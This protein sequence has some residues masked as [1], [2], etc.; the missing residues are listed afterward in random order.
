MNVIN[1][2][3]VLESNRVFIN[4]FETK[5]LPE[6]L[7]SIPIIFRNTKIKKKCNN[8]FSPIIET[9]DKSNKIIV[10]VMDHLNVTQ[11]KLKIISTN[12]K[13]RLKNVTICSK[14]P[15]PAPEM[16]GGENTQNKSKYGESAFKLEHNH[17][18]CFHS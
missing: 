14:K 4:M 12:S 9:I 5:P 10:K 11:I 7:P 13:W 1:L 17:V 2:E 18:S 3:D 15:T 6:Q 16:L 8:I